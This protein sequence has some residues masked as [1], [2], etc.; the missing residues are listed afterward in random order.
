MPIDESTESAKF[1]Q[2]NYIS[3]L[4]EVMAKKEMIIYLIYYYLM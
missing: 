4:S 1:N 2:N 3:S